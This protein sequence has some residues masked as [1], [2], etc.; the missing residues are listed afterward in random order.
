MT[1]LPPVNLW[2]YRHF[3]EEIFTVKLQKTLCANHRGCMNDNCLRNIPKGQE[4]L[5]KTNWNQI[6]W[7]EY[8]QPRAHLYCQNR[9][10]PQK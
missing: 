10:E 5:L 8:H 2:S 7:I 4:E 9:M 6:Q 1:H 3:L